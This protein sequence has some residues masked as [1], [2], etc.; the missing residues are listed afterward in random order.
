MRC[1][2]PRNLQ[3]LRTS[4]DTRRS[5]E[6]KA[7]APKQEMRRALHALPAMMSYRYVDG[8]TVI[9][10]YL[11]EDERRASLR[12]M[13]MRRGQPSAW[14]GALWTFVGGR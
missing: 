7:N 10:V 13:L 1:S 3:A 12:L 6:E 2:N 4:G 5:K 8:N 11:R 9:S 14:R